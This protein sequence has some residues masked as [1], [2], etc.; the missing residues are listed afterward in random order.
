MIGVGVKSFSSGK[1][2]SVRAG[3]ENR[4]ALTEA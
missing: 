3:T 1:G 4:W 2:G